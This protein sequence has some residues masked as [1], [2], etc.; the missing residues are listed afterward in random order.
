MKKIFDKIAPWLSNI[1]YYK[2]HLYDKI[3]DWRSIPIIQKKDVLNNENDFI[4]NSYDGPAIIKHTSGSSGEILKVRWKYS[5]YCKSLLYPWRKRYEYNIF[6][7]DKYC[8]NHAFAVSATKQIVNHRMIMNGNELSFSKLFLDTM[9]ISRYCEE[10]KKFNPKWLLLQPTF[11][12]RLAQYCKYSGESFSNLRLIE[13]TGEM[14]PNNIEA[15]IKNTFQIPVINHYGMTEFGSISYNSGEK[16]DI[17]T[18]NVYVEIVN[19]FGKV[20]ELGEEGRIII[21]TLTNSL[22]PLIRYDTGDFGYLYKDH[23]KV[24]RAKE[25]NTFNLNGRK[26]DPSL[27]F[28]L[29]ENLNAYGFN[30]ISFQYEKQGDELNC[31]FCV[32]DSIDLNDLSSKLHELLFDLYGIVF[33]N[34]NIYI[35]KSLTIND[36]CMKMQYFIDHS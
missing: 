14:L 28:S 34:V 15:Y 16:C 10:I 4:D 25:S 20:C 1:T 23:L 11:A 13:L 30:I 3:D 5:E 35:N 12:Y 26:F 36:D 29:T 27:F 17:F 24:T 6:P 2:S 8:T 32:L 19:Q 18:D 33:N 7:Y 22:M 9:E 21:T 31:F